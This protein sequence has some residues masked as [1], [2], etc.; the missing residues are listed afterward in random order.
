M[1]HKNENVELN[2]ERR[3][4]KSRATTKCVLLIQMF[5]VGCIGEKVQ[6]QEIGRPA[7][8]STVE[9]KTEFVDQDALE[10]AEL[11][12][13]EWCSNIKGI[14]GRSREKTDCMEYSLGNPY[15]RYL[16]KNSIE[17]L[18]EMMRQKEPVLWL[19][20]VRRG[21]ST[22]CWMK[23]KKREGYWKVVAI[24][25]NGNAKRIARHEKENGTIELT[26]S[27]YEVLS[28]DRE[29]TYWGIVGP[30]EEIDKMDVYV[31]ER[32]GVPRRYRENILTLEEVG[33]REQ[34]LEEQR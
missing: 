12:I 1:W 15:A 23:V 22:I 26:A 3:K 21:K 16:Y 31:Y 2:I 34:N 10:S 30:D 9:S 32:G 33:M 27:R 11:G 13:K 18:I 7:L 17:G 19:F 14:D 24:G 8:G 29:R 20:P 6:P 5:V 25:G 4:M 28:V